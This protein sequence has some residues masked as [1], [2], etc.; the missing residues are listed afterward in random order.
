MVQ[1]EDA[2]RKWLTT[3]T[4]YTGFREAVSNCSCLN[5]GFLKMIWVIAHHN[6]SQTIF[7]C[8]IWGTLQR[9]KTDNI[10]AA[11]PSIF[12]PYFLLD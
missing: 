4:I 7:L 11:Q 6:E 1:N 5:W 12:I 8:E 10:R 3:E 9:H 2:K